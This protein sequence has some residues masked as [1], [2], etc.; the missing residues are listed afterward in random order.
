VSMIL[1]AMLLCA[2]FASAQETQ[3]TK[4]TIKP[5]SAASGEEMYKEYCAACHGRTG[6]GDGP[7][8]A[9]LKKTPADLTVLAKNNGGKFPAEHILAILHQGVADA[10]HGSKDM[11]IWGPL[12]GTL[13][14]AGQDS[15]VV[16]M[17]MFNLSQYIESIQGK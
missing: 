9:A 10:S 14:S 16:K 11:P 17:R 3:I 12:F 8:A 2:G 5:T 13:G 7:A 1:A 15:S 6:K 4:T